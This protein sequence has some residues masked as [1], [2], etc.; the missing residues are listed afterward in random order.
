M[1]KKKTLRAH[2]YRWY[3][4][5]Y[6]NGERADAR[7]S[8]RTHTRLHIIIII[9]LVRIHYILVKHC[10]ILL[11]F[12]YVAVFFPPVFS[13]VR[14]FTSKSPIVIDF[15]NTGTFGIAGSRQ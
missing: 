6:Y 9:R 7:I 2:E 15:N 3:T 13:A 8:R 1:L 10:I 12:V 4:Q 11:S 5:Y 14:T